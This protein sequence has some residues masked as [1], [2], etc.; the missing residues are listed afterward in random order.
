[1]PGLQE[2]LKTPG[3]NKAECEFWY[4]GDLGSKPNF[5]ILLVI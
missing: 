3:V 5:S 1:M 2:T 4:Q